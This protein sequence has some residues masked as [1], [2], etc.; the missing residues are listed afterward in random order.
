MRPPLTIAPPLSRS[1][2]VDFDTPYWSI[3][4]S[5]PDTTTPPTRASIK[6]P[7]FSPFHEKELRHPSVYLGSIEP[8]LT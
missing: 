4:A 2:A 3:I 8:T 5:V 1:R 6:N 7:R